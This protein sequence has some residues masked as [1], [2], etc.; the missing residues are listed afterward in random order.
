MY[1]SI[2]VELSFYNYI[3]EITMHLWPG[4]S[5]TWIRGTCEV[6]ILSHTYCCHPCTPGVKLY[7]ATK[8]FLCGNKYHAYACIYSE[9]VPH[10]MTTSFIGGFHCKFWAGQQAEM[11]GGDSPNT[12]P[13]SNR[14]LRQAAMQI[15]AGG[16]A[17]LHFIA[18]LYFK[19]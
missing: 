11:T 8:Y 15:C 9:M 1:N 2:E 17:G 4:T 18:H 3:V 7:T 13:A 14:W 10:F 19:Q 12:E 5:Q 6:L 16:S